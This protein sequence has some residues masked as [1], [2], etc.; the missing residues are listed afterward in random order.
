[1]GSI[2]PHFTDDGLLEAAYCLVGERRIEA[3][4][5]LPEQAI[6][7]HMEGTEPP[8]SRGARAYPGPTGTR[9]CSAS[10]AA[11][12]V[13]TPPR[14]NSAPSPWRGSSRGGGHIRHSFAAPDPPVGRRHV[15]LDE[16]RRHAL[17][18]LVGSVTQTV[19]T[20][21]ASATPRKGCWSAL[22]P[23]R[24]HEA[25]GQAMDPRIS[26]QRLAAR[27]DRKNKLAPP[28]IRVAELWRQTAW[29]WWYSST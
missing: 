24:F 16:R 21:R 20:T 13:S 18:A 26:L 6:R 15:G 7:I 22:R 5:N 4:G 10:T 1:M 25:P 23:W 3:D 17:T 19:M 2:Y 9:S 27:L 8:R 28:R 12:P 11:T 14:D 29:A